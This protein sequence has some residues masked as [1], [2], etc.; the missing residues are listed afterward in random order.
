MNFL[1]K[2]KTLAQYYVKFNEKNEP[3]GCVM[4]EYE[5]EESW[6]IQTAYVK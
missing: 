6:W 1:K 5:N 3:I 4:I 2:D